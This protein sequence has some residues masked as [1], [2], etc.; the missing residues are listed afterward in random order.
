M[1]FSFYL[2]RRPWLRA[3]VLRAIATSAQAEGKQGCQ[4]KADA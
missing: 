1:V 4:R 3:C 2:L